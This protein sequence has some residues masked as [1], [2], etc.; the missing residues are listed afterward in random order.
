MQNYRGRILFGLFVAIASFAQAQNAKWG[1]EIR[2]GAGRLEGDIKNPDLSPVIS[3]VFSFCPS[4]HLRLGTEAG[5]ADLKLAA[6]AD[7]AKLR[8]IPLELDLTLQFS[9]YGKVTPFVTLGGGGVFWQHL[10]KGTNEVI[11]IGGEKQEDFSYFLKT[12]GGLNIFLS[13]R[14]TW[15]LGATYRY[16]LTDKF[17]LSSIGDQNDAVITAFTGFRFNIGG[18]TGD[19]DHDGVIDRYDMDSSVKEDR[20]GYL[21]HDGVPDT[22]IGNNLVALISAPTTNGSDTVNPVIIHQPVLRATAG[23]DVRVRAEIF[24]NQRLLKAAIL[25]RSVNLR[26]WL[27]E[28]L[29]SVD[30]TLFIGT[31]PGM[32]VQKEG[33]EYCIVA[34]DEARNGVGYSGLPSRPNFVTVHGSETGW[35]IATGL[36][37]AAGWGTASYLV[38]RKQ[39]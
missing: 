26:N 24:E 36:A 32:A 22:Q 19:A 23:H 15:I 33:L 27:V 20:D 34:V 28:P 16:A 37:A 18:I 11:Q 2:G 30:G 39:N 6:S 12:A 10:R 17:D 9:P 1:L 38:F 5:F 35:R 7:T 13:P 29:T 14:I 8:I 3:G 25:Y 4:P 31:I 21:D